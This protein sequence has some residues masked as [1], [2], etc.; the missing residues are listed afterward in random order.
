MMWG[1]TITI[2]CSSIQIV[3]SQVDANQTHLRLGY[4]PITAD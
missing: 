1:N 4:M 2:D 3:A